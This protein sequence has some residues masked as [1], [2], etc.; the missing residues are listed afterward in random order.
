M[1]RLNH[2]K[3]RLEKDPK[4]KEHYCNFMNTM[5]EDGDA[6]RAGND[7]VPGEVYYIPHHGVYHRKKPDKLRVVSDCSAKYQGHSLNDFLLSGPDPSPIIY[8]V[9][10]CVSDSIQWL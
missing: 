10:Y 1:V 5:L 2:L 6:E 4:Y 3:K 8:L 7:A 9:Y